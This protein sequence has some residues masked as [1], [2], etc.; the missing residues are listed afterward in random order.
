MNRHTAGPII[1][2]IVVVIVM[3]I[4]TFKMISDSNKCGKRV[5]LID[6]TTIDAKRSWSDDGG[7]LH[8]KTCNDGRK[9]IPTRR[10]KEIIEIKDNGNND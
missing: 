2:F 6:G 4:G 3:C 1:I 9:Q 5:I 8:I 7:M 10:V